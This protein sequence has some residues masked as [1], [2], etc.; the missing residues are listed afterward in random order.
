MPPSLP[1]PSGPHYAPPCQLGNQADTPVLLRWAAADVWGAERHRAGRGVAWLS[2][3][4]SET[5]LEVRSGLEP[6]LRT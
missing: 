5:E 2:V 6:V 1:L 3:A 4:P